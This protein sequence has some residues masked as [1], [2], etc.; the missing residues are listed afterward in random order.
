MSILEK[1][2]N[3][4]LFSLTHSKNYQALQMEFFQMVETHNPDN[5]MQ[6]LRKNP[7]HIDSLLQMSLVYKHSGDINLACDFGERAIYG[8]SALTEKRLRNHFIHSLISP[9]DRIPDYTLKG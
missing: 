7:Y 4:T 2:D 1:T 5:I 3:F 8:N 6:I 9:K